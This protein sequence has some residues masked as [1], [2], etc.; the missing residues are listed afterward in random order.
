MSRLS[1]IF[2]ESKHLNLLRR[3]KF[4]PPVAIFRQEKGRRDSPPPI[5]RIHRGWLRQACFWGWAVCK[6]LM[7][8]ELAKRKFMNVCVTG[9]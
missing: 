1:R 2:I 3:D 5:V 7:R 8:H 9:M 6:Q 4:V